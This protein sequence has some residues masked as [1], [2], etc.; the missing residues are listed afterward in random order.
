[1]RRLNQPRSMEMASASKTA[2]RHN[3]AEV[4]LRSSQTKQHNADKEAS[5]K[6]AGNTDHPRAGHALAGSHQDVP[7]G[8]LDPK[9]GGR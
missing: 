9:D 3:Q 5:T 8:P 7:A 1:M 6:L 2:P 4:P